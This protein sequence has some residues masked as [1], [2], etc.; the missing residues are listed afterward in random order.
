MRAARGVEPLRETRLRAKRLGASRMVVVASPAYLERHGVPAHPDALDGH[1]CLNFSFRRSLDSW[2]FRIDG[3][4]VQRAIA[5]RFYGNSGTVVHG[6]CLGGAGLAR[7]ARFHVGP[8]LVAGRL[9]SVLETFNPG[10]AEDVHALYAGSE[11]L[12]PRLRSFLAFLSDR[13]AFSE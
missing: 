13:L 3:A 9:V 12:S 5:G 7:L 4:V 8:D 1:A 11:R 2:P 6:M 10:D